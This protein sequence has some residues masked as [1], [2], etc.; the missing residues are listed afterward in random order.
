[1]RQE[2]EPEELLACWTLLEDDWRLV[3]N[4]R[5]PTRLGFA[6]VLKFFEQEARFPR[7]AGEVPQAAVGYAADQV[8]VDPGEFGSYDFSGRTIKYHRAQIREAFGFREATRADE[9]ELSDW[10]AGEVCPVEL[11][12]QR[13]GEALLARC[14]AEKI[15]PPGRADRIVGAARSAF[16]HEFC[17]RTVSRLTGGAVSSLEELVATDEPESGTGVF[18]RLKADPGPLGL[19]T[20]LREIDK[21]E[22]V[23]EIGL[24]EDLFADAS[25]KLLARWRARAAQEYAA[26]MR[27]HPRPVRLT[28]LAAL[29]WSRSAEITVVFKE[30]GPKRLLLK[31]ANLSPTA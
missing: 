14:R 12:D 8:K 28:L 31:Y 9:R 13:V 23:R 19:E 2:W 18:S 20:L 4:K 5:G 1:M 29:C 11:D 27:K 25:E 6:L 22:R 3:G 30:A 16:E 10:L 26:W 7:H 15:E 24:P 17:E 21:L